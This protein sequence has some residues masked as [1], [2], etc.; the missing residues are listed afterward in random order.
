[1]PQPLRQP[2]LFD[3]PADAPDTSALPAEVWAILAV[4]DKRIGGDQAM[5]AAEIATAAGIMPDSSREVRRTR[6]RTLLADHFEALPYLIV[7]DTRGYYRP[8]TY[9]EARHY[10]ANLVSRSDNILVRLESFL[11]Q[12]HRTPWR[13]YTPDPRQI[14]S[15][16]KHLSTLQ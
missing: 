12:L 8:A 3:Q 1:M 10:I 5:D 16:R 11:Q 14:N 15:V 9:D 2:D 4:L 13:T 7:A 6:V